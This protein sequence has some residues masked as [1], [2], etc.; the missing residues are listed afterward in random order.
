M[1]PGPHRQG[2]AP[3]GGT[4]CGRWTLLLGA[5]FLGASP[6]TGAEWLRFEPVPVFEDEPPGGRGGPRSS[7][8]A[9]TLD[10]PRAPEAP[11]AKPASPPLSPAKGAPRASPSRRSDPPVPAADLPATVGFDPYVLGAAALAVLGWWVRRG[12]GKASAAPPTN[13]TAATKVTRYLQ[14]RDAE[15]PSA[16][17]ETGVARYL[18][19][20]RQ[21]EG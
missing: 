9:A 15:A 17:P 8:P 3:G 12:N 11:E 7:P 20:R 13:G 4:V 18:R 6:L 14:R 1:M 16:G 2:S 21:R 5:V 19:T 10:R